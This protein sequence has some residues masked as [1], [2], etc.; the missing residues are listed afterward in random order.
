MSDEQKQANKARMAEHYIGQYRSRAA[1]ELAAPSGSAVLK[2]EVSRILQS[3]INGSEPRYRYEGK[4][5]RWGL[6]EREIHQAI[7][8]AISGRAGANPVKHGQPKG[9]SRRT[10]TNPPNK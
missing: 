10:P 1:S 4:Y 6:V 2:E 3:A 8:T 9:V 7:D 5:I